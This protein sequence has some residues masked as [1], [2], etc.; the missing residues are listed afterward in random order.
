[1]PV[2]WATVIG[3]PRVSR[4]L[5]VVEVTELLHDNSSWRLADAVG[6]IDRRLLSPSLAALHRGELDRLI[7]VANDRCLT[8]RAADR[9]RL[10]RRTRRLRSALA[11]LA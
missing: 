3:E 5:A 9:W 7:L 6:E 4:A 11:G 8:I 1:M 2:D 10:W